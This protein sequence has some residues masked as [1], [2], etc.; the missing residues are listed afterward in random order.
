MERLSTRLGEPMALGV[1]GAVHIGLLASLTG[2][3]PA[4]VIAAVAGVGALVAAIAVG[5]R[6]AKGVREMGR[7]DVVLSAAAGALSWVI[8]PWIVALNRYTDAPPGTELIFFAW[9]L[10]GALALLAA[11][12]ARLQRASAVVAAAAIGVAAVTG[13][14]AVLASWE[15]PSSFSPMVRYFSEELWML[16]AGACFLGGGLLIARLTR[17]YGRARP[18]LAGGVG[19]AVAA[20]GIAVATADAR[21]VFAVSQYGGSLVMWAVA[22]SLTWLVW[23]SMLSRDRAGEAGVAMACAPALLTGL[24]ALE[25]FT[26]VAGPN[27][28][29]AGG[30]AGGVLL[31]GAAIL[32]VRSL[33]SPVGPGADRPRAWALI[34]AAVPVVVAL[35]GLALPAL[36]GSA[37]A[38]RKGTAFE[39]AWTLSG[40]ESVAAWIVAAAALLAFAAVARRSTSLALAALAAAAAYPLLAAT[41]YR[42]LTGWLPTDVAADLGTEYAW[43]HF[44]ALSS[45]P[46]WIALAG[47]VACAA[48]VLTGRLIARSSRRAAAGPKTEETK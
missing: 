34:L 48:L 4:P 5:W 33:E 31:T 1:L 43:I 15:R 46:A 32:G 29:I 24:L 14:A 6:E 45:P 40:W 8:A 28:M 39:V 12:V 47:A 10:W 42:S 23:T 27:P 38:D 44:D 7:R 20:I 13:A 3:V 11:G 25:T 2:F 21:L 18:V 22:W 35:A 26:G 16:G 9:V 36:G 19:A 37:W 17:T 41:P 30:I